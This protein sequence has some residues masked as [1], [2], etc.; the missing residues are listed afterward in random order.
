MGTGALDL[1]Q[2]FHAVANY[3]ALAIECGA[4]LVVA[5]GALQALL[6]VI[7]VSLF[8]A[9]PMGSVDGQSG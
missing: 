3:V 5:F 6:A 1:E 9:R 4:V 2:T 8:P 7:G